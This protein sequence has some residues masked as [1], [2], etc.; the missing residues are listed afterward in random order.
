[1]DVLVNEFGVFLITGQDIHDYMAVPSDCQCTARRFHVQ[2]DWLRPHDLARGCKLV[3]KDAEENPVLVVRF[4]VGVVHGHRVSTNDIDVP[5][6]ID[7]YVPDPRHLLD[8]FMA[9]GYV[10]VVAVEVGSYGR[11]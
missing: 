11:L 3:K 5:L 2:V 7:A 8:H 1:M 9:L 10:R 4:L 6:L